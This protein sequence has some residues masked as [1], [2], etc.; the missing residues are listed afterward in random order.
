METL[1]IAR[2]QLGPV[3]EGV[4]ID[5]LVEAR[6]AERGVSAAPAETPSSGGRPGEV[7]EAAR[8]LNI[9]EQTARNRINLAEDLEGH[10][11]LA[12]RVDG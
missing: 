7:A 3:A 9:P 4:A 1:N 2:R 11:D 12:A 5:K 8:E 6:K 10:P